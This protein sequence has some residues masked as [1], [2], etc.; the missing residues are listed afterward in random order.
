MSPHAGG[1]EPSAGV[2]REGQSRGIMMAGRGPACGTV[3]CRPIAGHLEGLAW[4]QSASPPGGPA[5][6]RGL[7]TSQ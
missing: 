7:D 3:T 4:S 1:R 5:G 2:T 6:A